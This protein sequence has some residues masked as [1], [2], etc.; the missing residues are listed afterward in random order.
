MLAGTLLLYILYLAPMLSRFTWFSSNPDFYQ[1]ITFYEHFVSSV[2][3]LGQ[4]P[5]RAHLLGSG[6]PVLGYPNDPSFDPLVLLALLFGSVGGLKLSVA[7]TLLISVWASYRL[8]RE[9]FSMPPIG[10]A[11][12]SLLVGGIGWIP[13]QLLDGNY[14]F[15]TAFW[16]PATLLFLH[17]AESDR[18]NLAAA[19]LSLVPV[20]AR[21]GLMLFTSVL[22]IFIF[23]SAQSLPSPKKWGRVLLHLIVV[24]LILTGLALPKVIAG[25]ELSARMEGHIHQPGENDYQQV[26]RNIETFQ[27]SYTPGTFLQY[28]TTDSEYTRG[29]RN[30]YI[31]V[32]YLPV[33]L[34]PLGVLLVR[35]VRKTGFWTAVIVLWLAMGPTAPLD[36]FHLL[37]KLVPPLHYLWKLPKYLA[38]FIAIPLA[39]GASGLSMLKLKDSRKQSILR[40]LMI[41][42]F[43]ATLCNIALH[44]RPRLYEV[45]REK[46]FEGEPGT[47]YCQVLFPDLPKHRFQDIASRG[48]GKRYFERQQF[49]HLISGVGTINW[50]INTII[51][52]PVTPKLFSQSWPHWEYRVRPFDQMK[53]NEAYRG[54][55][56]FEGPGSKAS[57]VEVTP[58]RILVDVSL[59]SPARL[60]L[61][62]MYDSHFRAS[63]G[64]VVDAGGLLGVDCDR[65]G[66]Y[67]IT[68]TLRRW[69][70]ISAM[71]F[72]GLM[73][74]GGLVWMMMPISRF[75]RK[76]KDETR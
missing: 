8:M 62:Q 71:G 25:L 17:R 31:Y 24:G 66:R 28:F 1:H 34:W 49:F 15:I 6:T 56:W 14:K 59:K 22:F 3:D 10:A 16:A 11:F 75:G 72:S 70:L 26:A 69:D 21:G 30:L 57:L 53:M 41:L 55:V 33:L 58:N 9:A 37:W 60:I 5:W 54:E 45:Y 43:T 68:L 44:N 67:R 48:P 76:I 61:N 40:F 46:P 35:E 65:A 47:S 18:R 39:I 73:F 38:P 63:D 19:A 23:R 20:A 7:A 13:S 42:L 74:M 64:K 12:G 32:G 29:M 27:T 2:K 36:L 4:F 51:D 52:P 50:A